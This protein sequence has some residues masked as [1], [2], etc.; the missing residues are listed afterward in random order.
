MATTTIR[1]SASFRLRADLLEGLKRNAARENRTLNNYVE[2]VLLGIVF[3]EP[4]EVT[5]AAIKEAKSGK[6]PNKV[7]DDIDELFK[8]LDSDKWKIYNLQPSTRRTTRDT[9]ELVRLGSHSEL[10][11]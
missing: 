9:I 8:D 2:S 3:D 5:K 1:K 10:F 4:N 7:Y 6:N 11:K